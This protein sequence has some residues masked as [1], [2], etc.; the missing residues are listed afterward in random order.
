MLL[1]FGCNLE[2]TQLQ[3]AVRDTAKV[4][5]KT[6]KVRELRPL[7]P[8]ENRLPVRIDAGERLAGAGLGA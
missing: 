5:I 1:N 7:T 6:A 2:T 4:F 8:P 3:M